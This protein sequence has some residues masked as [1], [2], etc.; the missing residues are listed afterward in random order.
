MYFKP[1]VFLYLKGSL[2]DNPKAIFQT[3]LTFDEKPIAGVIVQQAGWSKHPYRYQL[4]K[5]IRNNCFWSISF[6]L[7]TGMFLILNVCNPIE[8][9]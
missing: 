3:T 9:P 1:N 6:F 4:L 7:A 2:A 8:R 5:E